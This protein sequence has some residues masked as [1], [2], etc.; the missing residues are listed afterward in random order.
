MNLDGAREVL[1]SYEHGAVSAAKAVARRGRDSLLVEGE[2]ELEHPVSEGSMID[3]L[4]TVIAELGASEATRELW[5]RYP[6]TCTFYMIDAGRRDYDSG[7]L[8][9]RIADELRIPEQCVHRWADHFIRFLNELRL[10]HFGPDSA[11]KYKLRSILLHGGFPNDAWRQIWQLWIIPGVRSGRRTARELIQWVLSSAHDAPHMRTTT[12]DMLQNGG[13]VVE[14]LVNAAVRAAE[15][16]EGAGFLDASAA[17]YGLPAEALTSLGETL[18]APRLRWP[19]MRFDLQS[20]SAVYLQAPEID[21]GVDGGSDQTSIRYEIFADGKLIKTDEMI[22]TSE[23]GRWLIQPSRIPLPSSSVF[24]AIIRCRGIGRPDQESARRI[25]WQAT[26]PHGMWTFVRDRSGAWTCP[27]RGSWRRPHDRALCLVPRDMRIAGDPDDSTSRVLSET[28]LSDEWGGWFAFE[29]EVLGGGAFRLLSSDGTPIQDLAFGQW[30]AISLAH[31]DETLIGHLILDPTC[32]VFGLQLPDVLVEA[33]DPSLDLQPEQWSCEIRWGPA[34]ESVSAPF[35]FDEQG[36]RLR[37]VLEEL[38]CQ[39]P[40][41]IDDGLIH[42]AGPEGYGQ[43]Q[44]R[45]ARI[46]CSRPRLEEIDVDDQGILMVSYEIES[47]IDLADAVRDPSL[48]VERKASTQVLHAPLSVESVPACVKDAGRSVAMNITLAGVSLEAEGI[49][50]PD[51][52][53]P[54]VI[55]QAGLSLIAHGA[56]RIRASRGGGCR[57]V[58]ELVSDASETTEL[59][60]VGVDG[61]YSDALG[62]GELAATLPSTDVVTLCLRLESGPTSFVRELIRIRHGLGLGQVTIDRSQKPAR[63]VCEQATA[64]PMAIRVLDLTAP[65]REGARASLPAGKVQAE[66]RPDDFAFCEGRYGVWIQ[67]EDEWCPDVDLTV[68]P[69][70]V[71]DVGPDDEPDPAPKMGPYHGQLA[72]LLRSRAGLADQPRLCARP[73]RPRLHMLTG[74]AEATVITLLGCLR[75]PSDQR[76]R[77]LRDDETVATLGRDIMRLSEYRDAISPETLRCL[78]DAQERGWTY[79]DVL[80]VMTALR[81]PMSDM[82]D[83][84]CTTLSADELQRA[85]QLHPYLGLLSSLMHARAGRQD[86][87]AQYV[88][89]WFSEQ[90]A[91]SRTNALRALEPDTEVL[92][93]AAEWRWAG[94]PPDMPLERAFVEWIRSATQKQQVQTAQWVRAHLEPT[95]TALGRFVEIAGPLSSLVRAVRRRDSGEDVKTVANLT[96]V[97]GALSLAALAHQL[98]HSEARRLTEALVGSDDPTHQTLTELLVQGLDVCPGVLGMDLSLMRLWWSIEAEDL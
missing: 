11:G 38:S 18:N 64:V 92:S 67:V 55:P 59:R 4:R 90:T 83:E 36:Y 14:K 51:G 50:L 44:R 37:A 58:L 52:P 13:P 66:L 21:L 73:A 53:D 28:P 63:L 57:V 69:T 35:M 85:W 47:H 7:A 96:L 34:G 62:I 80:K 25:R 56:L 60:T 23:T 10:Q 82:R 24:D 48:R 70:L 77:L 93:E 16:A 65:W 12:K 95:R 72:R 29:V 45:F 43:L 78:I 8:Y 20:Q 54:L 1:R 68:A 33:L 75:P 74:D 15:K 79:Q 89:Q 42:V 22:A 41:V 49:D 17:D 2:P 94:S 86:E 61:S 30:C 91:C 39:L 98:G 84:A 40:D 6:A 32:P 87:A 3:A 76:L 46:P 9:P 97:T 26:G 5:R 27:P 81:M 71:F 19:E 88:D 31:E